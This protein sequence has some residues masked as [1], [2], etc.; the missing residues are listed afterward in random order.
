MEIRLTGLVT[1][2]VRSAFQNTLIMEKTE[3][4]IKG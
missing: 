3:G 4:R 1:S 2:G